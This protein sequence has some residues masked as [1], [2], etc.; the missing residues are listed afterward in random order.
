MSSPSNDKYTKLFKDI[1]TDD[2]LSKFN[3]DG[4]YGKKEFGVLKLNDTLYGNIF[5]QSF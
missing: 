3:Y 5:I 1:I 2:L 4:T